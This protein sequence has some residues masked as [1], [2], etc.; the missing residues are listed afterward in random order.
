MNQK[1]KALLY[2]SNIWYLGEGMLGPLFAIYTE[3]IGGSILDMT[4]AWAVY[5][6]VT[7]VITVFVGKWVSSTKHIKEIMIA[8][9]V[10]NAVFTFTYLLVQT[11]VH[12]FFVQAGLG[13]ATA[14]ATPTWNTLYARNKDQKIDGL[15]WG[16]A[17]GGASIILGIA[18]V[19]GGVVVG[20][21]SFRLL[22]FVMGI[23][24]VFSTLYLIKTYPRR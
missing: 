10:L 23:I 11:P 24:Q 21:G 8:G 7:G 20:Y 18:I 2:S 1:I 9:Y 14:L 15:E 16:L 17:D 13:I 5:L 4:W 19:L 3:Q 12:L 6:I 22:F